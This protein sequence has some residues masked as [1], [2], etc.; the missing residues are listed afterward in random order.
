MPIDDRGNALW[1]TR[2]GRWLENPS[3]AMADNQLPRDGHVCNAFGLRSGYNPYESG[4]LGGNEARR[5]KDLRALSR[6]IESKKHR[7]G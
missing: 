4:V 1:K 2:Q 3:L 6:W 7:D 5:K